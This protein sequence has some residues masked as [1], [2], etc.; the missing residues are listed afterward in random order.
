MRTSVILSTY[1]SPGWLRKVLWGYFC[2]SRLDFELVIA[3]DGS[4]DETL[5]LL[6]EMAHESP[7]PLAHV[8]QPDDG[9]QK[10]R[11]LN[12]AIS[13][14]RGEQLLVSDGDCVPRRD[15][16]ATHQ[17]RAT[18]GAFLTCG[19]FK[20]PPTV[21]QA[22]T[23]ADIERQDAFSARW[24]LTHGMPPT[25]KLLKLLA[26]GSVSE[27]LNRH[28]PARLSWNG[29]GASCLKREALQVNGF[30]EAMQ[31]GGLDV[32]FGVR[33]NHV[34]IRAQHIRYS[35][36]VVHLHHGHGYVTPEMTARNRTIRRQTRE[37]RLQR[38]ELGIDQWLGPDGQPRLGPDDRVEWLRP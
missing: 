29:H 9:F 32:E 14:A 34:G 8:W 25:L 20:L 18:P 30:N 15:F 5:T 19:Y 31:Y 24:L 23:R 11:I 37:L 12:K 4:R 6:R 26:R 27:W 35:S 28:T 36:T 10:C 16:V 33:L 17:D 21:S 7:V 3:D 2:Q 1:N 38:A 13:V 22:L